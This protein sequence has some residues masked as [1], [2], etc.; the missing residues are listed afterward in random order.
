MRALVKDGDRLEV[1][2]L[3]LPVLGP[4]DVLIKVILAEF[5]VPICMQTEG[6]IETIDPL[7]FRT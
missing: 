6:R 7:V 1:Q 2:K 5:V 4:T 3:P